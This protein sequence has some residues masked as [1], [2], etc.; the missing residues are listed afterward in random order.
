[1]RPW[2]ILAMMLG[3]T[4]PVRAQEPPAAPD[5]PLTAPQE[6]A[7]AQA[8]FAEIRCVVCQHE[9][10]AASPAGVASDMR[11]WVREQIAGGATDAEIRQGLVDRYGDY[12]LFTPPLRPGTILLWGLP[13]VLVVGGGLGLVWLSR[14]RP[15]RV[16]P[17]AELTKSEQTRVNDLLRAA[18][19]GPEDDVTSPHETH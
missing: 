17:D 12:V 4:G 9:S 13:L 14:R 6:E 18:T 8:L 3:L 15:G 2:L 10:I 1:M 16:E 5:T 7:R 19:S 11:R